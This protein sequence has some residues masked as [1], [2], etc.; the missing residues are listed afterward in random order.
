MAEFNIG[1]YNVSEL[2]IYRIGTIKEPSF[3]KYVYRCDHKKFKSYCVECK[4]NGTG[5]SSLCDH[6]KQRNRCIECKKNGTGGLS[7]CDHYDEKSKCELCK[8]D[9]EIYNLFV[10]EDF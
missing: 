9:L 2:E 4:K 8:N 10:S 7:L 6:Y 1:T 3:K 5:G